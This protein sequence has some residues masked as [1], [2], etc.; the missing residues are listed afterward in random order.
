MCKN[1]Q[2]V[3]RNA[4][5]HKAAGTELSLIEGPSWV[6]CFTWKFFKETK[7]TGLKCH[8]VNLS[9]LYLIAVFISVPYELLIGHPRSKK[10]HV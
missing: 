6:F 10:V 4:D 5:G 2:L 7:E 1:R 3:T 9:S 8:Y